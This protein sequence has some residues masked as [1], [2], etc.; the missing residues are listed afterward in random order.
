MDS[1][2]RG[3]HLSAGLLTIAILTGLAG[4]CA[5]ASPPAP[6]DHAA[7]QSFVASWLDQMASAS[8]DA[9]W[10]ALSAR[11][12]QDFGDDQDAY[13]TAVAESAWDQVAWTVEPESAWDDGLYTV[14]VRV[15]GGMEKIPEFLRRYE[16]AGPWVD[17]SQLVGFIVIVSGYPPDGLRVEGGGQ[18]A[19]PASP[20]TPGEHEGY[21]VLRAAG[22]PAR[23][24]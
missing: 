6:E 24:M 13:Q 8:G 3:A 10:S 12:Q 9:G 11:K 23:E 14:Y 15:E 16:L 19:W 18:G 17:G 22:N 2:S 1:V 7:T 20:G 21:V 5:E 4:G